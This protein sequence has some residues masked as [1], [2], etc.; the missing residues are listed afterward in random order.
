MPRGFD[1]G[2]RF[3]ESRAAIAATVAGLLLAA[4]IGAAAT[5]A[6]PLPPPAT[7]TVIRPVDAPVPGVDLN[8]AIDGPDGR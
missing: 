1:A 7:A 5:P 6:P 2:M 3:H 8:Q 4:G